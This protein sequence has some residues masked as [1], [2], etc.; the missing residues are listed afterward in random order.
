MCIRGLSFTC[1]CLAQQMC[2]VVCLWCVSMPDTQSAAHCV[3]VSVGVCMICVAAI[4]SDTVTVL[5]QAGVLTGV[6]VVVVVVGVGG[7]CSQRG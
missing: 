4:C 1:S 5:R 7:G 6:W 2:Q 3:A